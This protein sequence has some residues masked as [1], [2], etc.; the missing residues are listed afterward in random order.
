MNLSSK[1]SPTTAGNDPKPPWFLDALGEGGSGDQGGRTPG[2]MFA[3]IRG[4]GGCRDV[5]FGASSSQVGL[6]PAGD[7]L[8][9]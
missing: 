4:I 8:S 6:S 3:Y 2:L 1:E 9:K 5:E 7:R